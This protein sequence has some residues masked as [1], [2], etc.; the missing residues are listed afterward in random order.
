MNERFRAIDALA[1]GNSR[2]YHLM[3]LASMGKSVMRGG[4]I[5]AGIGGLVYIATGLRESLLLG[6]GT[7][8]IVDMTINNLRALGLASMRRR[9]PEEYQ[10]HK[11]ATLSYSQLFQ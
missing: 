2:E 9:N 6:A 3:M 7:F 11:A 8:A 5:G 1:E 10:S 4:V